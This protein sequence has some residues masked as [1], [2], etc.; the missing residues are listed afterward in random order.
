MCHLW[1]GFRLASPS[2]TKGAFSYPKICQWVCCLLPTHLVV[3]LSDRPFTILFIH[4]YSVG[5]HIR[6][7]DCSTL[8]ALNPRLI[9][10]E[11]KTYIVTGLLSR[12]FH[13]V[14]GFSANSEVIVSTD[15]L[16]CLTSA[17]SNSI[18]REAGSAHGVVADNSTSAFQNQ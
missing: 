16:S 8:W 1:N 4:L 18:T 12:V 10:Q 6:P 9:F 7:S 14:K 3:L 15:L 5:H 13:V 17:Y 11:K 2:Q